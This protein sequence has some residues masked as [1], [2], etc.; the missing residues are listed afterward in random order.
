[1]HKIRRVKK[2]IH[3]TLHSVVRTNNIK[4]N[5]P[6]VRT[7]RRVGNFPDLQTQIMKLQHGRHCRLI[8]I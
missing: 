4:Y 6:Y 1:M 3:P 8:I 7:I 5:C 2:R